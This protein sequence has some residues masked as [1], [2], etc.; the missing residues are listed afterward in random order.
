MRPYPGLYFDLWVYSNQM[1]SLRFYNFNN[2]FFCKN[3]ITNQ[4]IADLKKI[5]QQFAKFLRK[6]PS[7]VPPRLLNDKPSCIEVFLFKRVK[8]SF[9]M[10]NNQKALWLDCIENK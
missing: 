2:S 9:D 1:T 3:I 5:K 4:A 8:V 7:K 10:V 6:F